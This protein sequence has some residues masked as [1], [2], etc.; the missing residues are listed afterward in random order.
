NRN[1]NLRVVTS[2]GNAKN[3]HN[4]PIHDNLVGVEMCPGGFNTVHRKIICFFHI[5]PRMCA[6]CYDSVVTYCYGHGK[7]L[8]DNKSKSPLPIQ[9][10]NLTSEVMLALDKIKNSY[11]DFKGVKKVKNG[12]KATITINLE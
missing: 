2:K 12:W 11:T 4:D 7:R 6:L 5:D 3:K 1:A 9:Y 8:N 10:W